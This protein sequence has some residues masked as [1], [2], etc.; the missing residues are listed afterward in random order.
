MYK[1]VRRL[2]F[3]GKVKTWTKL[4]FRSKTLQMLRIQ[5]NVS[6][7]SCNGLNS[8]HFSFQIFLCK[9]SWKG[10][11]DKSVQRPF[12]FFKNLK[13]N[14]DQKISKKCW[15]HKKIV[16][17]KS[18]RGLKSRHFLLKQFLLTWHWKCAKNKVKDY[19][20]FPKNQIHVISLK[21]QK[22]TRVMN[23]SIFQAPRLHKILMQLRRSHTFQFIFPS[24][25]T[26]I[27][28]FCRSVFH[29]IEFSHLQSTR[30]PFW[31]TTPQQKLIYKSSSFKKELPN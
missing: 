7:K 23:L 19:T 30:T 13:I 2:L 9:Y 14:N 20:Q 5:K 29:T 6:N 25:D 28:P 8:R 22:F 4:S 16:S 1:N 31:T 26:L 3:F 24:A 11:I 15:R 12:Y 17:N 27:P 18:C 21:P 10:A